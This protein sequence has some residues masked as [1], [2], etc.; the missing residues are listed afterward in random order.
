MFELQ[1][2]ENAKKVLESR[3]LRKDEDGDVIETPEA[4][5]IRVAKA[6]AD[7]KKWENEFIDIMDN[8]YFLPNSPCLMN[9][10]IPGGQLLAC[11]VLPIEDNMES[12]METLKD[13]ALIHKSGGK[14]N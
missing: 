10:G 14:Q 8:L 4:M 9:A 11:F 3:I 12:I 7:G 1:L 6:I 13:A 2:T 5:F